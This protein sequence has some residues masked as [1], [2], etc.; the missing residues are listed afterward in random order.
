METSPRIAF[1]EWAVTVDAQARGEQ[2]PILRPSGIHEPPR[3]QNR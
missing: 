3:L 2:V 1:E